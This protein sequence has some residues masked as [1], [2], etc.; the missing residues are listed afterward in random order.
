MRSNKLEKN[1]SEPEVEIMSVSLYG[2]WIYVKE[3]EYFL[4]FDQFPWFK[5]AKISDIY[6]VELIHGR[7]LYWENL[8]VDLSL[9]SLA[10]PE[11][12]PLLANSKKESSKKNPVRK[13]QKAPRTLKKSAN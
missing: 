12:F 9:D 7:H 3:K 8:D 13:V 2:L 5:E 4:S 6:Q 1:T 10:S 11:N